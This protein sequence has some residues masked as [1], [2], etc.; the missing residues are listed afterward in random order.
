MVLLQKSYKTNKRYKDPI[1]FFRKSSKSSKND[2]VFSV[3]ANTGLRAVSFL[4]N[5]IFYKL[6][7]W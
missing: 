7:S 5:T 2:Y 1:N 4:N 6:F 3:V